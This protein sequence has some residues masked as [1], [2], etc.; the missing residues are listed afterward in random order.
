[1]SK[2]KAGI[3]QTILHRILGTRAAGVYILLFAAAIGIA[4][5]VEN[6]FGT[7][8]AQKV[9][10]KSWWFELLLILFG[11]SLIYNIIQFRMVKAKKWSFQGLRNH[12]SNRSLS[13]T[14]WAP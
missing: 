3:F 11:L 13:Y 4:T 7:S 12:I 8:S 9:I 14:R 2:G 1:M 6:D 10:F 5:F